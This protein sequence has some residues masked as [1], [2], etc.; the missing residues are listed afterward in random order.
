[1][2]L[3]DGKVDKCYATKNRFIASKIA[4]VSIGIYDS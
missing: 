4:G 1:M 2:V 3:D